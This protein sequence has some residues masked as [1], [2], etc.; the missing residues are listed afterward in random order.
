MDLQEISCEADS[1]GSGQVSVKGTCEYCNE[2]SGTIK[3]VVFLDELD[4]YQLHKQD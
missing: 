1:A 4:E 3:G 2:T